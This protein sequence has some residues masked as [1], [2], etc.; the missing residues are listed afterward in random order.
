ARQARGRRDRDD[1]PGALCAQ[2]RQGST[3]DVDRAEQGGLD[4][5]TEVLRGDL[6][7]EAG[8]EVARVVH[9]HVDPAESVDGGLDGS[10]R[11]GGVGDVEAHDLEIVV[12]TE[13]GADPL[14]IASGGYN[15]V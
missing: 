1:Q 15:G 13:Y 14:G 7:E 10:L 12:V 3:G 6:L 11:G 9:Q 8:V 5:R 2:N 4:L